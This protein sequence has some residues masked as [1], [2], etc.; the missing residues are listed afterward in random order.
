[1]KVFSFSEAHMKLAKVFQSLRGLGRPVFLSIDIDAFSSAF[2]P[3]AS[4]SYPVGLDPAEFIGLLPWM[5]KTWDIK[6]LGIYEVSP[7]LDQDNRTS[8][9]AAILIHN[10][11]NSVKK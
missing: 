7:P 9:L 10:F 6:G 5:S 8:K 1:V 3:G 2:A 4:A 11:L